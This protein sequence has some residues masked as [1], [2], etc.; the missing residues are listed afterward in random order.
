MSPGKA[1]L[2]L[3]VYVGVHEVEADP[4]IPVVMART[5]KLHP[6]LIAVGVA[7]VGELFGIVG[8]IV[9]VPIIATL[10]ILTE[11]LWIKEIEG[12][13]RRT[14]EALNLPEPRDALETA[15]ATPDEVEPEKAEQQAQRV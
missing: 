4:I 14:A 10:A 5:V 3:A 9:A 6:A 1:L 11:E 12:A 7:V 8:L 15:R 2:V 13:P